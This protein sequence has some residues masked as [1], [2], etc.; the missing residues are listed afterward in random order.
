M[1]PSPAESERDIATVL[2][3]WHDAAAHADEARY[4]SHLAPN[5][6]F[7]GT[8]A[9][10]RWGVSAFRAYAHPRFAEGRAWRFHSVARH[11]TLCANGDVAW[12]D[13]SLATERLGPARGSGTLVKTG[14]TWR[15]SQYDLSLTI[16]NERFAEVRKIL[17]AK[18]LV[19]SP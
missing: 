1:T 16:P 14:P 2:D 12:F 13:E 19:Q 10:E 6:V 9:S 15:I 8:D 4:F 5:A 7:L 11:I 18:E 17:D 3:D